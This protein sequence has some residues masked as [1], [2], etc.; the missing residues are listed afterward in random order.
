MAEPAIAMVETLSTFD[1]MLGPP[2]AP[3]TVV[4][5]ADFQCPRCRQ[6]AG[7]VKILLARFEQRV[8]L[9][10]RHFPLE[11]VHP[12]ALRAA[13]IAECAA[14][15][16]KFWEMHDLLFEN[17]N[18]LEP[19]RLRSY[20]ECLELDIARVTTELKKRAHRPRIREHRRSGEHFRVRAT[21]TFFVNGRVQD[22]SFG[23]S[24]LPEAVE[25]ELRRR[26]REDLR[27]RN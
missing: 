7:A 5:Y 24:A 16:T 13:E 19:P 26:T 8:R 18:R 22:V 4:E 21:P 20:A 10:F 14:V 12:R 3:V 11:E 15:Q 9:V 2:D 1:H 17:Q 6:A 25:R 27:L 23:L